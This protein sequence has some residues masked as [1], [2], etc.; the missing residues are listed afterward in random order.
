MGFV[1]FIIAAIFIAVRV[2]KNAE[3]AQPPAKPGAQPNAAQARNTGEMKPYPHPGYPKPPAQR[4]QKAAQ[5]PKKAAS[6]QVKAQLKA[7]EMSTHEGECIESE[8]EHC[9]V[10]HSPDSVY[11][12]E[13][14]DEPKIDF[15]REQLVNGIIMAELLSKPKCF[16][17]QKF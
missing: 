3:N 5:N 14:S 13:I 2:I 4:Q 16:E 8:P 1:I 17:N 7:Q 15:S 6:A 10:K 11:A 12:T 9:A